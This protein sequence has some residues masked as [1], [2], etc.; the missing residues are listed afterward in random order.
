MCQC[1]RRTMLTVKL[2]ARCVLNFVMWITI[3]WHSLKT[4]CN[5]TLAFWFLLSVLYSASCV[6][7]SVYSILDF[8]HTRTKNLGARG[9]IVVKALR[10]K[11]AGRRFDSW[12]CHWNFS[13]TYSFRSHYG[14]GVDSASNRKWVPGVFAGVKGGRTWGWQPYHHPVPLSWNLGTLTSW[15]P[16]GHSRPVMGLLYPFLI[17]FR[18]NL[19]ISLG[20][21][22]LLLLLLKGEIKF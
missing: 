9:G 13:V 20:I 4:M 18:N 17:F 12:W 1:R 7:P 5:S 15:N 19:N 11:P 10:Y 16:L 8:H 14:P 3:M 21:I 2:V 6:R 22:T